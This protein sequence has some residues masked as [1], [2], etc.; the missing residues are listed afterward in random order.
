MKKNV[1]IKKIT[2][3]A[4]NAK[5]RNQGGITILDGL[6]VVQ[7]AFKKGEK[8]DFQS[9]LI[10][11][12]GENNPEIAAFISTL[13]E[14]LCEHV[15][16]SVMEKIAP[17]KTPSG[18]LGLY[19]IPTSPKS[20]RP[21]VNNILLLDRVSDPGNLGTIIRSAAAL[22]VEAIF[23]SPGCADA[24]SPK[25]LRAAQGAHFYIKIFTQFDLPKIKTIFDGKIIGTYLDKN[26]TSLYKT[27]LGG[28]IGIVLGNEGAGIDETQFALYGDQKVYI[29]MSKNFES[30]NVA[31]AASICLSEKKRQDSK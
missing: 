1:S 13:P 22:G 25:V 30:L 19:T 16:D 29:P 14:N 3:Y 24:W 31:V 15:S 21:T 27:N 28:K 11:S 6:H 7:E 4:R 26:A 23:C 12:K 18:I 17:T 10:S 9:I 5:K 8:K 20:L 2:Q